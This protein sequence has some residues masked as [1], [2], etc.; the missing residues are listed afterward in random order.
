MV[1]ISIAII[2]LLQAVTVAIVGGLFAR[3][4]RKTKETIEQSAK[5]TLIKAEE[6]RL[7]M[8][9]ASSN[10]RLSVQTARALKTN[11]FNGQ[12]DSALR[13]AE[14]IQQEY[15]NFINNIVAVEISK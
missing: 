13:E 15:Y 9:M 10:M 11:N 2:G 4:S 6:S 7:S 14:E 5:H 1:S 3:G 8:K 12:L